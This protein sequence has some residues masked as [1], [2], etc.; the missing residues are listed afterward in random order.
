MIELQQPNKDEAIKFLDNNGPKPERVARVVVFFGGKLSP[1]VREYLVSPAAKRSRYEETTG[2]GHK[3]PILYEA[4]PEDS[5]EL[6]AT[7]SFILKMSEQLR[8]LFYESFDGY[9]YDNCTDCCLTRDYSSPGEFGLRKKWFFFKR[10][11]PGNYLHPV[12]LSL[13]VDTRGSDV[14]RWKVEKVVYLN[15][16]FDS[17]EELMAAYRNGSV[18]KVFTPAPSY[19][20]EK[21]L[22]SSYLR[23]GGSHPSKPLR[24]PQLVEPDGKRYTVSGHHVEYM[25][26]SFDFRL[27]SSTGVQLFDIS[28]DG[29]R[30]VYELSLQEAAAFYS[31]WTRMQMSLNYLDTAFGM[32]SSKSE[33]VPDIDCP[34]TATF[35]DAIHFVNSN[36]PVR[37]QGDRAFLNLTL[38]FHY[39]GILSTEMAL[40]FMVEC[41]ETFWF[42][43][44]FQLHLSTTTLTTICS[45]QMGLYKP[46]FPL[47]VTF[48]PFFGHLTRAPMAQRYIKALQGRFTTICFTTK[49]IWMSVKEKTLLKN[50]NFNIE[51]IT[52]PWIPGVR[53]IQKVLNRTLKKIE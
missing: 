17:V 9:T 16:S 1:E 32:G 40:I 27:R 18:Y 23:R 24:P 12:G 3:Y 51:N 38:G 45:I 35:M 42:C 19:S 37:F 26:W 8:D 33:L 13:Y 29:Q 46:T 52:N 39:A 10:D 49:W 41:R 21:L 30:I 28:F 14:S 6:D 22:F 34:I 4:R 11:L 48:K 2:P 53:R 7:E 47:A 31:G 20:P 50:V 25:N 36:D 15:S 44:Q 5:K 43:E